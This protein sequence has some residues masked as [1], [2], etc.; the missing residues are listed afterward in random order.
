MLLQ[1]LQ[2]RAHAPGELLIHF[3]GGDF[4][5]HQVLD[6]GVEAHLEPLAEHRVGALRQ[7]GAAVAMPVVELRLK[8][9]LVDLLEDRLGLLVR[10]VVGDQLE[11]GLP[12]PGSVDIQVQ[13]PGPVE[14]LLAGVDPHRAAVHHAHGPPGGTAGTVGMA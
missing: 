2:R 6:Q 9:R 14:Q 10:L 11:A 12:G 8:D 13:P 4:L 5:S 3:G 1:P 7:P